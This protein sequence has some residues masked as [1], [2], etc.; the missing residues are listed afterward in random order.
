[1][2]NKSNRASHDEQEAFTIKQSIFR[3]T[4]IILNNLSS[5]VCDISK[6]LFEHPKLS[7][8]S[9]FLSTFNLF[10]S[11]VLKSLSVTLQFIQSRTLLNICQIVYRVL[12]EKKLFC[13]ENAF[14]LVTQTVFDHNNL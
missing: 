14:F 1:M 5:L 2:P 6:L 8:M 3:T 9:H 4:S 7:Q 12:L 13:C 11:K 10:L